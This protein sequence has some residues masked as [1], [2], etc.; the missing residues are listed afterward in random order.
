MKDA[1]GEIV[2]WVGTAKDITER[3]RAEQQRKVAG[4][5]LAADL[6]A[7]TRLSEIGA[8]YMREGGIEPL[9]GKILDAAIAITGADMGNIQLLD[10]ESGGLRIVAQRGF[11]QPFLDFW[12]RVSEGQGV[13]GTA[14]E[15]GE[16]VIVEDVTQS[17]IFAS[18]PALQVQL[19]AGVRAVQS[20]PL[21]SRSGKPLGIF[22][23]HYK[24]PRRPDGRALGLLDLL[25]RLAAD[26]LD[27]AETEGA[28]RESQAGLQKKF[29]LQ[30]A[31]LDLARESLQE[32]PGRRK[33][34]P[35]AGKAGPE[36]GEARGGNEERP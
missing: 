31:E 12:N 5:R 13:C 19:K 18:T 36:S 22:S 7:M 29:E 27:R 2:E 24:T 34:G 15:R 32:E 33:P 17:S 11:Q 16:R 1:K 4:E 10:S 20:T 28:L 3:R 9:L 8:L 30:T 14:L 35:K 6:D 25:A 26:I 21:V 23:T